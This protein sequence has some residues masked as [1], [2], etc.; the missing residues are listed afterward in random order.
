MN[1]PVPQR[2]SKDEFP[3]SWLLSSSLFSESCLTW[4]LTFPLNECGLWT[5]LNCRNFLLVQVEDELA[6]LRGDTKLIIRFVLMV[7]SRSYYLL[8]CP[9]TAQLTSSACLCSDHAPPIGYKWSI[10]YWPKA[11]IW[12]IF[13]YHLNMG[14][15]GLSA[16][17]R[18]FIADLGTSS[19]PARLC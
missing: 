1:I 9:K 6:L 17:Q 19:S 18:Q 14:N 10:D 13:T 2:L 3:E 5:C 11:N 7:Q 16:T 15:W 12:R 4:L 8:S